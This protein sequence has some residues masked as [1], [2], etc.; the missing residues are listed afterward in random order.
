MIRYNKSRE[1]DLYFSTISLSF[2]NADYVKTVHNSSAQNG[3]CLLNG[4][5]TSTPDS[6]QKPPDFLSTQG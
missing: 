3:Y 4:F 6:P 2:L 5:L 1:Y